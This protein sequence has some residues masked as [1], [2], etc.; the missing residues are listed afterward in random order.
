[1]EYL[2]GIA[3][4]WLIGWSYAH[5]IV[6]RECR[7]LGAFYVNDTVYKCVEIIEDK[8]IELNNDT[9]R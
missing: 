3:I 4:G 6:A 8:K 1:M 9:D 5:Y 2:I 7:L